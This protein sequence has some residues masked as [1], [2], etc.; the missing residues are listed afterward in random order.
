LALAWREV[1]AVVGRVGHRYRR[2]VDELD[3]SAAPLP[4]LGLVRAQALRNSPAQAL[5]QA[6]RQTLAC[7]AIRARVQAARRRLAAHFL[8][9][10][11]GYR[12]LAA[13]IGTHD[14]LDE[15]HQRAQR[16]VVAL[17]IVPGFLSHPLLQLGQR[18]DLAQQRCVPIARIALQTASP[19]GQTVRACYSSSSRLIL[20]WFENQFGLRQDST[21]HTAHKACDGAC[22]VVGNRPWI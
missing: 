12:I 19:A 18:N 17:T 9:R 15:Q 8:A 13:V 14:L 10:A 21:S 16:P 22:R 20:A 3:L 6:Q 11:A 5:H 7:L 2:A 1:L 4:V